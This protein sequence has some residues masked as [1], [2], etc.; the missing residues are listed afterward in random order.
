MENRRTE[1]ARQNDDSELIEGLIAEA[2][3][4]AVG[5][6]AG[7]RLQHDVGSQNDLVR[8][9]GDPDALTRPQKDDDINNDQARNSDRSGDSGVADR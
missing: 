5:S 9:V 7:G 6:T 8:A 4:G 3:T 2:E 1:T